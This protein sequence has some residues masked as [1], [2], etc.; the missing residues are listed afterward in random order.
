MS[1]EA[2]HQGGCHCGAVR[3]EVKVAADSAMAC[4]CSMCGKKGTWLVFA[5][6]PS[7]S[8][9][10]GADNLT[11]YQFNKHVI[12][13]KFCKTCGVTSFANGKKPDGTPM[14][15]INVRCLDDVDLDKVKVNHFD[16]KSR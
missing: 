6:E 7:F 12:H 3:Y 10:S 1:D 11:D 13:H 8:L 5:D 16:G 9:K 15:A 14:V 4:N 2:M